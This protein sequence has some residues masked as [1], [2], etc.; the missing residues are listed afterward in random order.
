MLLD[1]ARGDTD[2]GEFSWLTAFD[3]DDQRTFCLEI[4]DALF[5]AGDSLAPAERCIS[6]WRTTAGALSIE[7]SRRILIA[8]GFAAHRGLLDS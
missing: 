2:F 8:Q 5:L 7:K 1:A 6:E 4:L 3:G